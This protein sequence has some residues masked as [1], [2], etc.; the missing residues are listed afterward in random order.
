[1]S[2]HNNRRRES[3]FLYKSVV[4]AL[5][6][7]FLFSNGSVRSVVARFFLQYFSWGRV[8]YQNIDLTP[9]WLSSRAELL[10]RIKNL[11]EENFELKLKESDYD[12][13][14]LESRKL[15]NELGINIKGSF[16]RASV[17]ARSPQ[18][19][20]DTVI[21]N[22]GETDGVKVGQLVLASENTAFGYIT[23][24]FTDTSIV[25]INSYNNTKHTGY[26][27]RTLEV[28]DIEGISSGNF[29]SVVPEDFDIDIGDKIIMNYIGNYTLAVV[30]SIKEADSLGN[31]TILLSLPFD[32]RKTDT[33]Y[34][35]DNSN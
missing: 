21:I 29:E 2:L 15:K 12:A 26:V 11:E 31:K 35:I 30:G 6:I 4:S 34:V 32:I 8:L 28:M 17:T 5:L 14:Y 18:T 16:L 25:K 3:K 20:F 22:I 27:S 23:E 33:L 7:F 1:M 24:V 13:L 9:T 10:D 19:L